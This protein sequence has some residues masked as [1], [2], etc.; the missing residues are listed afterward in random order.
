MRMQLEAGIAA[1][2]SQSDAAGVTKP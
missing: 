1:K 2:S